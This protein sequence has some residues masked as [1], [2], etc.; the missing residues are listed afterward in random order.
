MTDQ[1]RSRKSA[2]SRDALRILLAIIPLPFALSL[3]LFPELGELHIIQIVIAFA[4]GLAIGTITHIYWLN[5]LG[6]EADFYKKFYAQN[7]LKPLS[8]NKEIAK[9]HT[10]IMLPF[11]LFSILMFLIVIFVFGIL[12]LEFS[13]ALPLMLGAMEGVP[14]SY[15]LMKRGLV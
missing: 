5:V 14:V 13:Y 11:Y 7:A 10:K 9:K 12:G 15:F 3:S 2:S 4:F 1:K 6:K 8:N